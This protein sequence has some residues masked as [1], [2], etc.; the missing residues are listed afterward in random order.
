MN[1]P[2][3]FSDQQLIQKARE[4]RI[5]L[6]ETLSHA[7]SGHT[8]GPLGMTDIFAALYFNILRYDPQDPENDER[9][10][11][12][13][14]NGHVCPILYVTMAHA[15]YFPNEELLTLRKLNSRLQGHPW[16]RALPG[17]E[18]TSGPLGQG[19]SQ[20]VGMALRA[21]LDKKEYR[22]FCLMS[23]AENQEGQTW[24]AM[25]FA[26]KYHLDNLIFIID[27]NNIQIDGYIQDVMP[28]EPL[29]DKLRAFNLDVFQMNGNN[30]QDIMY[31]LPH[32]LSQ[33]GNRM[34]KIIS[35]NTILGYGVPFM[36]NNFAWHGVV[37]NH[38]QAAEALSY[39]RQ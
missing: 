37:P 18:N 9:D 21:K 33:I 39:L 19:I 2:F 17:I 28:I 1:N 8:G 29:D 13:L 15:G 22:V 38:E 36:E 10:R 27:K 6:I 5:E 11:L 30:I 26:A 20:A 14:S 12:I 16:N 35:A 24:E 31:I 34:P 23:D 25:L 32:A 4:L 7:P 3:N